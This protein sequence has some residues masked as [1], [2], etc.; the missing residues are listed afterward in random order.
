MKERV[1]RIIHFPF[2]SDLYR[3]G[4]MVII[5]DNKSYLLQDPKREP[6]IS[7][8]FYDISGHGWEFNTHFLYPLVKKGSMNNRDWGIIEKIDPDPYSTYRISFVC[9]IIK[10]LEIEEVFSLLI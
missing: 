4:Q 9:N 10:E 3:E 7:N 1:L 6:L 5:T 8:V 2:D